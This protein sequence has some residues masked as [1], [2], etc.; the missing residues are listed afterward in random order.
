MD[1]SVTGRQETLEEI[2]DARE[3]RSTLQRELIGRH[4]SPIISFTLNIAGPVKVF[5]LTVRTFEE[6]L[7]LITRRCRAEGI[8]LQAVTET[9]ESTGYEAL[10]PA[11]G[12]PVAIK[13]LMTGLEEETPLGR[14]FD[15][16][17]IRLDGSKVSRTEIGFPER[18]CL[19]C[20]KEA[21]VCARSRAHSL[22]EILEA[23]CQIMKDHQ[24]GMHAELCADLAVK[25][26]LYE[27]SV[28]PKP[29]LV[30][31]E[32]SGSHTDMDFFSFI[33]SAVS[34]RAYFRE[35]ALIGSR[36]PSLDP[37]KLFE[38]IRPVGREAE[39]DMLEATGGINTHK[40]LIFSL[41]IICC[42]AGR[43]HMRSEGYSRE[44]LAGT[45]SAMTTH[46]MDDFS[47][48]SA[49]TAGKRCF[50]RYGLTGIRGEAAAGFPIVFRTALPTLHEHLTAGQ[51]F[52]D[53]CVRTLAAIMAVS[54]DTNIISRSSYER[55]LRLQGEM[56]DLI[57]SERFTGPEGLQEVSRLDGEFIAENI[58]PGGS[59]D[60]LA[61]TI[62]LQFYEAAVGGSW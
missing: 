33:D 43:L 32:N 20:G 55:M 58:S 38:L 12:D 25:A 50:S 3:H 46:L 22:D 18:R 27:V 24:I 54:G 36:N 17:V 62:F 10:I 37:V 40:G 60:I 5:P 39:L 7:R 57:E 16:D 14:L 31:R 34:L 35:L 44:Q 49:V 8:A 11:G 61:L 30:D 56:Q 15:I 6:G 51:P 29:G 9:R 21:A 53:A 47:D 41:G 19:L 52:N 26:L 59:A 1:T 13:R 2:L 28:T 48:S 4:D 45:C 23:S 42:A